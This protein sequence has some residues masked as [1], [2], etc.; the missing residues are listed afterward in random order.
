M[1]FEIEKAEWKPFR[2]ALDKSER[3]EFDDMFD[4]PR[5]YLTACSN[6]VQLVPLHPII[7]S[8][9]FHH[10][11]ELIQLTLEVEQMKE[12]ATIVNNSSKKKKEATIEEESSLQSKLFDF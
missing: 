2:N 9:L 12:A 5:L 3:K 8:I 10:Y 7:I 4:I 1:A 11:K 6:S